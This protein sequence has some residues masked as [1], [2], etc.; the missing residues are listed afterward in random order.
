MLLKDLFEIIR[1]GADAPQLGENFHT[2]LQLAEEMFREVNV[3]LWSGQID[4]A[5]T[6]K[7]YERDVRINQ[8]ER[9]VRKNV[10]SHLTTAT[11]NKKDLP[12]CFVLINV[13]KDAERIGDYVKNIVEV[14]DL[15]DFP[16]GEV[17]NEL[18]E[19][20]LG[21]EMLLSRAAP[22]FEESDPVDAEKLV[23]KGREL[24]KRADALVVRI[25][26]AGNES[27]PT[28]MMVLLARFY[29]RIAGHTANI[30]SSV[31]MPLH[32]IDYFDEDELPAS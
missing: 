26:N 20:G 11:D 28:C 5:L 18:R 10:L 23:R 16:E 32:K 24:Q 31:I 29:K 21:T 27:G 8:L 3:A 12:F 7:I 6:A 13:V 19:I 2:M 25:A 17:R 15:G 4:E 9:R 1:G 14:S 30:L 22:C